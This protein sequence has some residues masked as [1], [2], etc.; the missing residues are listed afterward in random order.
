VTAWIEAQQPAPTARLDDLQKLVE[1]LP[2]EIAPK[3]QPTIQPVVKVADQSVEERLT[4]IQSKFES[5]DREE[6]G[7]LRGYVSGCEWRIWRHL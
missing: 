6:S 1:E 2:D 4:K 3:L 5:S 7:G